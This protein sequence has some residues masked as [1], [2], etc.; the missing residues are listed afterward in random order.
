MVT[1]NLKRLLKEPIVKMLVLAGI[2][3][4][5]TINFEGALMVTIIYIS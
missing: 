5:S 2:A 1:N 3:Y 4:L